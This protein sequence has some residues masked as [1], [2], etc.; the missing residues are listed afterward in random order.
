[1]ERPLLTRLDTL[2]AGFDQALRTLAGA[3]P[4][5]AH[6]PYPAAD[7]PP[8]G[9]SATARRQAGSLMRVNHTGEVCAQALYLGQATA[10]LSPT[11]R[12]ALNAAAAEE[13]EHLVW[14]AQRLR[15]LEARPSRL[16]AAWFCGAFALG[17]LAGLCGEGAS[18]GFL[19]ETERQ[20]VAHLESHLEALPLDDEASRRIVRQMC[21][22]EAKHAATARRHGA[23][24]LPALVRLL[25]KLQA[26]VMTTIAARF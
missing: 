25:M 15:E 24:E 7:C 16:N 10:E 23:I 21:R 5:V 13:V 14:C 26:K 19:A 20:V 18:M 1:M 2:I 22:D 12:R 8:A 3:T 17:T 6:R 4:E 9:L 11:R